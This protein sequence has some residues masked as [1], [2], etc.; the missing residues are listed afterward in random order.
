VLSQDSISI[1]SGTN[2][3]NRYTIFLKGEFHDRKVENERSFLLLAQYLYTHNNVRYLVFE[4]GPDFSYLANRY[5]QTQ[6]DSILFKNTLAFSKT[7]WDAL[8]LHNRS[9]AAADQLKIAGFDFN[10]SIFTARAFSEMIKG[11][12]PFPDPLLQSTI[13]KIIEWQST[14]WTWEG[15]DLFIKQMKELRSLCKK[16]EPALMAYFG[17]EWP[18]FS[19]IVNHDVKSKSTVDRDKTGFKYVKAFL[20]T[21]EDGN[22]L[23]NYG[24]SH[25]FL[26]GI[27]MG[28]LLN[29]DPVYRGKV[30]SLYPFYQLPPEEKSKIQQRKDSYLPANFLAE[31]EKLPSYGLVNVEQRGLYPKE[32]KIAQWVYVIPKAKQ[33]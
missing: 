13:D 9:R 33:P 12:K 30:C 11:K 26:N 28:K 31:L 29:N 16:Q 27:G 4:W 5:L 20:E 8:A 15:Q 10:R 3:L 18:S 32:F 23:F 21:K 6:N 24:I 22:V 14:A 7:F 2:D 19:A 17:E 1:A 25:A